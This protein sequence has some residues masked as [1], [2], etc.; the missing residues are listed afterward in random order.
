MGS[1]APS[2]S[3]SNITIHGVIRRRDSDDSLGEKRS[4]TSPEPP[5]KRARRTESEPTTVMAPSLSTSQAATPEVSARDPSGSITSVPS[6]THGIQR[7]SGDTILEPD[8]AATPPPSSDNGTADENV[9]HDGAQSSEQNPPAEAA[10][11]PRAETPTID[12][13]ENQVVGE[14][15]TP[16]PSV[17]DPPSAS[18]GM[19]QN[20]FT[21]SRIFLPPPDMF[22]SLVRST[23]VPDVGRLSLHS[24]AVRDGPSQGSTTLALLQ[25]SPTQKAYV[26]S[27]AEIRT[28]VASRGSDEGSGPNKLVFYLDWS[29]MGG[30]SKWRNFKAGQG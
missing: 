16:V 1:G 2:H 27:A 19:K 28:L 10:S 8:N 13:H 20:P 4:R 6:T 29:L 21:K 30:I 25:E 24:P 22:P 9:I 7:P 11:E 12:F 26:F 5:T 14:T 15:G 18:P 17:R 23:V 3:L